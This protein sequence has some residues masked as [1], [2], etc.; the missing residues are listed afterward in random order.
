MHRV[1]LG[2]RRD[3]QPGPDRGDSH[4]G[5]NSIATKVEDNT[6]CL[7]CH[8]THAPFDKITP[9]QVAHYAE[10]HTAIGEVVSSHSNHP[11]GPER[12]MG[13]SRCTQCHMATTGG[14]GELTLHG[15]TFEVVP[16][17][18]TLAY[19][20]QGGMPNSCAL[21]CHAGKVNSFNLGLNPDADPAAWVWNDQFDKDLATALQPTTGRTEA[22]GRHRRRRRTH[23]SPRQP[24][25][26]HAAHHRTI[27]RSLNGS[28]KAKK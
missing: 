25:S 4:G 15:Q 24:R 21:S 22:G 10:N 16:P 23:E 7:G 1:P 14:P 28:A 19:Q 3:G 11:Y 12:S 17:T 13:L 2:A 9:D 26:S 18:K 6:L 27:V 5:R 8:A 20:D